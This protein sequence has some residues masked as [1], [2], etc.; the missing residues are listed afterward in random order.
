MSEERFD[1]IIRWSGKKTTSVLDMTDKTEAQAKEEAEA[2]GCYFPR[3][4]E[5]WKRR[6]DV[7]RFG[8]IPESGE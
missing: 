5:F 6:P 4:F 2:F 1:W 7:Q 3:R 8:P